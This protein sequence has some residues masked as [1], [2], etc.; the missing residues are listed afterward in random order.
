MFFRKNKGKKAP[1][2]TKQEA[3]A[4]RLPAKPNPKVGRP[5]PPPPA[6][7]ERPRTIIEPLEDR[8]HL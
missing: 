3:P 6:A 5:S 1:P 8:Q 7:P 4:D 2:V